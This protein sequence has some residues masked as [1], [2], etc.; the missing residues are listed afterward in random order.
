MS[1]RA[2]RDIVSGTWLEWS[3]S[4]SPLVSD[5]S[6]GMTALRAI[7]QG[8]VKPVHIR[9]A[10]K[11]DNIPQGSVVSTFGSNG[12]TGIV[13]RL[14]SASA[15]VEYHGVLRKAS[16]SADIPWNQTIGFTLDEVVPAVWEAIPWSWLFDYVTNISEILEV[17][18]F[19]THNLSFL[20]KRSLVTGTVTQTDMIVSP[21][22]V[23]GGLIIKQSARGGRFTARKVTKTR[24]ASASLVTPTIHI[25]YPF[26]DIKKVLN[27]AAVADQ[28][29]R[30]GDYI[31]K[32]RKS[33]LGR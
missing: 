27:M 1:R 21:L 15:S 30:A 24:E 19:D 14:F 29:E 31:E 25:E 4:I 17:M 8:R 26:G 9:G 18:T 28:L 33:R 20:E 16:P 5:I 10:A 23:G 7:Q 32:L 3:F 22:Q 12:I 11:R 6:D 13:N 2:L